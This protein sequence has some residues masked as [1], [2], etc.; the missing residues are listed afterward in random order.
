MRT[1]TLLFSAL[2]LGTA[3]NAQ[4]VATFDD[5]ILHGSDTEYV[6][7]SAPGTNTGFS[8]GLAYFPCVY[9]TSSMYGNSWAGG[10]AYSNWTDSTTVA[11]FGADSVFYQDLSL[12]YTAK[13]GKGYGGSANYAVVFCSNPVTYAYS[14]NLPLTGGA[15]GQPVRGFYVT[16]TCY[17]YSSMKYGDDFNTAFTDSSWFLLT[18]KGYVGGVLTTDSVNFYLADTGNI[19]NTWEWVNLLPLGHVDSLQFSLSASNNTGG[20]MDVPAFFAMDNF[21]TNESDASVKNVQ[22]A[23]VAKVYPNPAVNTLYV[24]VTDNSVQQLSVKDMAGNVISTY[25]VT[26]NHNEI[27][28]ANLAA[29]MYMLQLSGNGKTASTKFVKQ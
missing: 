20:Y 27:N 3:A 18:V 1:F 5:L 2:V 26:G 14:I 11:G 7:Y 16:N 6:N 21:T 17:A 28:T 13:T 8:D 23:Y 9:D 12:E 29:G 24:D 15:V 25:T 19:V 4:T 22:A 10:F